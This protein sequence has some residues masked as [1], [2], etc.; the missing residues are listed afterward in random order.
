M[1]DTSWPKYVR[2]PRLVM[3]G[4]AAVLSETR[5]QLP[6]LATNVFVQSGV[7]GIAAAVAGHSYCC[8]VRTVRFLVL[9]ILARWRVSL[10]AGD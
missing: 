1:S 2:I 8:L 9:S 3:Q 6:E 4:Y 5:R 7:G 10:K